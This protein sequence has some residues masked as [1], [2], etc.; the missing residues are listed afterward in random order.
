MQTGAH[1]KFKVFDCQE[2]WQTG[3]LIRY[4]HFLGIG[5]IEREGFIFYAPKRLI[6]KQE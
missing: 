4:D 6:I 3:L 5:E 2:E 1:V